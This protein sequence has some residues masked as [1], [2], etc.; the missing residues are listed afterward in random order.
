[1]RGESPA[2]EAGEHAL[3]HR[4][5]ERGRDR[6]VRR[7]AT[8]PQNRTPGF[9]GLRVTRRDAGFHRWRLAGRRPR[10]G[11]DHALKI[12]ST[13][14]RVPMSNPYARSVLTLLIIVVLVAAAG[15]AWVNRVRLLAKLLGQPESRIRAQIERRKR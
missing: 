7:R 3:G 4:G 5:G 15:W 14:E 10:G 11:C 6:S 13:S 1:V 8:Q 9:G 2:A 12:A